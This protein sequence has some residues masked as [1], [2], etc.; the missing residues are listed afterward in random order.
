MAL[1]PNL[2]ISD[3]EGG[4]A[5]DCHPGGL[6]SALQDSKLVTRGRGSTRSYV[7]HSTALIRPAAYTS[8]VRRAT[9]NPRRAYRLLNKFQVSR[10]N[11]FQPYAA[12]CDSLHS[13][14]GSGEVV[15]RGQDTGPA[16]CAQAGPLKPCPE[17]HAQEHQ[18]S[19][20]FL[21]YTV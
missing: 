2:R 13:F 4:H 6:T 8:A 5:G 3:A 1:H 7:Q 10:E 20:L 21:S 9:Q 16:G 17:V 14:G 15:L 18:Q 19:H 12:E 11:M